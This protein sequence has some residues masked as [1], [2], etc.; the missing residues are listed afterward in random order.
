[1]R[2]MKNKGKFEGHAIDEPRMPFVKSDSVDVVVA[3]G[4]FEHIDFDIMSI[5]FME[6][7]RILKVG[8][9]LS[10]NYDNIMSDGGLQWFNK[11]N[12]S[13]NGGCIFRFYTSQFVERIGENSG[14]VVKEHDIRETRLAHIILE[15]PS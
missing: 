12:R 13:H 1:M 7:F 3:Q 14:F 11:Y 2:Y 4:V 6:F 10:F 5:Y 8:G 9:I 15:K